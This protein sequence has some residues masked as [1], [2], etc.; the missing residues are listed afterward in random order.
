MAKR[1]HDAIAVPDPLRQNIFQTSPG[2]PD[3]SNTN[4]DEPPIDNSLL[5]ESN[6]EVEVGDGDIDESE[7]NLRL[8]DKGIYRRYK[9]EDKSD[10][11]FLVHN[12][13][14]TA[15][16]AA[17]K[18][19]IPLSTV[20]RWLKEDEKQ[21]DFAFTKEKTKAGRH[22]SIPKLTDDQEKF[23]VNEIDNDT[24]ITINELF[25]TLTSAY[26][27]LNVSKSGISKFVKEYCYLSLK[28][29]NSEE[30]AI[31]FNN[32][33]ITDE[34][35]EWVKEWIEV[36]DL[37]KNCIFV[38]EATYIVSLMRS[39]RWA[40]SVNDSPGKAPILKTTSTTVLGAIS[41]NGPLQFEVKY[42]RPAPSSTKRRRLTDGSV[43]IDNSPSGTTSHYLNFIHSLIDKL[44]SDK[45]YTGCYIILDQENV[46]IENQR[47][48][49][50]VIESNKFN[51]VYLPR[52][53]S[54]L[55]AIEY[56]WPI[57]KRYIKRTRLN[58]DETMEQRIQEGANAVSSGEYSKII[59]WIG[60][61]MA[62]Y[63]DWS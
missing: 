37:S 12:R 11:F 14:M 41:G 7:T 51:C 43:I 54:D 53:S 61:S 38:G 28:L 21:P 18:I 56:F 26:S 24:S 34:R 8:S 20:R 58:D 46:P 1:S 6:K 30:K 15:R 19:G 59:S 39:F 16:D 42:K 29:P 13:A 47:N 35:Y 17:L 4:P 10:I 31:K 32:P 55:N 23:L 25:G 36:L 27:D 22:P 63:I 60:D 50:A 9:P 49:E 45:Q 3:I 40:K 44:K 52:Q 48:I 2:N 33:E 62:K 57:V 5:N